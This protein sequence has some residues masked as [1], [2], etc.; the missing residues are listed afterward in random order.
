MV[1]IE[2]GRLD[3]SIIPAAPSARNLAAHLRA[4]SGEVMNIFAATVADQCSSTMSFA[5]RKRARGVRA[6]LAW[7]TKASWFVKR[8]LDS[9][10]SQPEAFA[11]QQ[12]NRDSQNN[13]PGHHT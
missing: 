4:V 1:G 2:R 12:L 8:F 6:A 3:L 10:T 9:S 5:S 11:Y 7:D 13:V